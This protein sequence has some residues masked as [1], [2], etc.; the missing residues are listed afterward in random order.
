[1]AL[2]AVL[3]YTRLG[4]H[5]HTRLHRVVVTRCVTLLRVMLILMIGGTAIKRVEYASRGNDGM[6]CSHLILILSAYYA[7]EPK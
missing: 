4:R 5:I 6:H 3:E 7:F 1:M 2:S